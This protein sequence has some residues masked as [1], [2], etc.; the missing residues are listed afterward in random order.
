MSK[1]ERLQY[2]LSYHHNLCLQMG[3]ART[4]EEYKNINHQ[5][6]NLE[7]EIEAILFDSPTKNN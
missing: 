4:P 1:Q 3:A 7:V 5:L 6:G 2:L